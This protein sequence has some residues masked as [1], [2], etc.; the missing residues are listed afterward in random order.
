MGGKH[1]QGLNLPCQQCGKIKYVPP[2]RA[3]SYKYCSRRCMALSARV[4]CVSICETCNKEFTHIASRANKAKYCSPLCY[5]RAMDKKGS[6]TL[7]CKHCGKEFY[8]SPSDIGKRK[9][10]SRACVN[11]ESKTTWKAVFSTVRKNMIARGMLDK[12]ERCG[13][14]SSP[15]ILGVHHKD[16][17]RN[18]NE[19]ENL[20]VLCPNC[21]SM[22][23]MK[24]IPHGFKE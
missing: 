7:T 19:L 21:H 3:N 6:I 12:C 22:E 18:N 8:G 17:N 5:H 11:K 16:R 1:N 13:F 14:D 9:Y 23:H 15:N 24:H 4:S 2:Y 10:C 20:E